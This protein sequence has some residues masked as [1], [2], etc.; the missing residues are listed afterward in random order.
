MLLEM[1]SADLIFVPLVVLYIWYSIYYYF[2]HFTYDKTIRHIKTF[3][4][5]FPR[6]K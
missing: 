6:T 1:D 2:Q 4:C 3:P 5:I